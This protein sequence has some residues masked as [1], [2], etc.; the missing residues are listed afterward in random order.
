[1]KHQLAYESFCYG[2][3]DEFVRTKKS[4]GLIDWHT[5]G[6]ASYYILICVVLACIMSV[7]T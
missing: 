3:M 4:I 5:I 1:M 7:V 2:F 6:Q